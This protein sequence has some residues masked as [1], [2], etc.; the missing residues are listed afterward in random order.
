[1]ILKRLFFKFISFIIVI[2]FLFATAYYFSN[3]KLGKLVFDPVTA[4]RIQIPESLQQA[5][6]AVEDS[7]FYSHK[8]FDIEGIGRAALVNLQYGE[9]VECASTITQ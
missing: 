3:G 8:G 1:M 2:L 5:A 9:V 7:R 4:N 6:I